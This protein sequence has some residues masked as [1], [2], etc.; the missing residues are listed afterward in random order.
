MQFYLD[1]KNFVDKV[2]QKA[3]DT[4]KYV[5]TRLLNDFD[6]KEGINEIKDFGPE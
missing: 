4:L 2:D 3:Y 6:H 5:I 1:Y